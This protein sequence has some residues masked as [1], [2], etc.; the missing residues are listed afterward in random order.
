MKLPTLEETIMI[1]APFKIDW[2]YQGNRG[3][4]EYDTHTIFVGC[5]P[6]PED[7]Y[8]E[9][10]HIAN[11]DADEDTVENESKEYLRLHPHLRDYL[12]GRLTNGVGK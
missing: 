10:C 8:H 12:R 6:D 1:L 3:A 7:L 9:I 11:P 4:V 2:E 5:P